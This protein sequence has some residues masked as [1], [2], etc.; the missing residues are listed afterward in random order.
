MPTDQHTVEAAP[1]SQHVR[2]EI[3][4]RVVAESSRPVLVHETGLPVRYYLPPEDVA[5]ELL[6]PTTTRT[7]CPY[8]GDASYWSYRDGS[9]RVRTDVVWSYPDPL[10]EVALIKDHLSFYDTAADI[11]ID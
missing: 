4:G 9:G 8:K 1:G 3:D 11:V 5:L 10:P 2:V 7:H 6:E